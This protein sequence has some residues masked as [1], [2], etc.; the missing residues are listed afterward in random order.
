MT[1]ILV[2]LALVIV[3]GCGGAQHAKDSG[4]SCETVSKHLL[5]LANRDNEGEATPGLANGIHGEFAHECTANHW[6]SARRT[7]LEAAKSQEDTLG[8]PAE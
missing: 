2:L 3:V 4:P 8:C 5:E 6:S 7:C 1:K